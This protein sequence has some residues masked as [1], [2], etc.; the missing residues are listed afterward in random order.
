M[1]NFVILILIGLAV[2][3]GCSVSASF[4]RHTATIQACPTN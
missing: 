1:R 3:S 4:G 2:T